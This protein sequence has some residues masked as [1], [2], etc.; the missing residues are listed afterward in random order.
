M[1]TV[2]TILLLRLTK[3]GLSSYLVNDLLKEVDFLRTEFFVSYFCELQFLLHETLFSPKIL[4]TLIFRDLYFLNCQF[5]FSLTLL[6]WTLNI[7]IRREHYKNPHSLFRNNNRVK[8]LPIYL[9]S[10]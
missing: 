3:S 4:K 9:V 6:R 2:F 1:H 10:L 5:L 7:L 8:D